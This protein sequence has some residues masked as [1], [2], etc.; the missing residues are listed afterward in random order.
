MNNTFSFYLIKKRRVS[1]D[2]ELNSPSTLT[3]RFFIKKKS[4]KRRQ[5]YHCQFGQFWSILCINLGT[6]SPDNH[7]SKPIRPLYQNKAV[8]VRNPRLLVSAG[9]N[10]RL[11]ELKSKTW[12]TIKIS[13]LQG[14]RGY[15]R[16]VPGKKISI[17]HAR[18]RLLFLAQN[19]SF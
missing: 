12:R 7:K 17:N 6:K 2:A 15:V 4:I 11:V 1:D 13:V 8:D 14:L 5:K 18:I 16:F 10:R 3:F 9:S 19:D